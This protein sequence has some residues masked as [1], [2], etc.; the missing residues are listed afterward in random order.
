M[1]DSTFLTCILSGTLKQFAMVFG[2]IHKISDTLKQLG[3]ESQGICWRGVCYQVLLSALRPWME[4]LCLYR[5]VVGS[6]KDQMSV[7]QLVLG[8][9]QLVTYHY[10]DNVWKYPPRPLHHGFLTYTLPLLDCSISSWSS[11]L[12]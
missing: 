4:V 10:D 3:V 6:S 7:M 5:S 12:S 1:K 11:A 9:A 8:R 2:V